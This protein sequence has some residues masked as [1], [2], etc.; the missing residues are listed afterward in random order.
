MTPS[1]HPANPDMIALST[2]RLAATKELVHKMIEVG[3]FA[4]AMHGIKQAS[5][6]AEANRI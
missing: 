3:D 2:L 4:N 6:L 5:K 1:D